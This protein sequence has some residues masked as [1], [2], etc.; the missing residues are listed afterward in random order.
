MQYPLCDLFV[1]VPPNAFL[2]LETGFQLGDALE[3][4]RCADQLAVVLVASPASTRDRELSLQF[5]LVAIATTELTP[6]ADGLKPSVVD[7]EQAHSGEHEGAGH[8]SKRALET[9]RAPLAAARRS[10]SRMQWVGRFLRSV[11]L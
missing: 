7:L 10:Q 8:R 2:T 4:A 5:A 6:P 11:I 9:A 3:L 1:S